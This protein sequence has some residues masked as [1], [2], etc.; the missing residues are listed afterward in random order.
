MLSRSTALG[1]RTFTFH[2]PVETYADVADLSGKLDM[3]MSEF[4][5]QAVEEKIA[6]EKKK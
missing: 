5:R 4:I 6:K 3:S 1:L 2:M